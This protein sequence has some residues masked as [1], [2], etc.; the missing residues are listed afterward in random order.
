M[1]ATFPFTVTAAPKVLEESS[2]AL[3]PRVT[4][5]TPVRNSAKYIEQ[6]IY[7]VISQNYPNLEYIIVDGAS[8]DG[9]IDIIRRYEKH[10]AWWTSEPDRSVYDAINKGFSRSSGEV[11]GWINASDVLHVGS[12]FVVGS[13][14]RTF[15]KVEWL[16]GRPTGLN[17]EGTVVHVGPVP[18]WS[19]RRFLMGANKYI[20]Q[21]STFWRRSLWEKAG[22]HVDGSK[23][24]VGDFDLWVRFF[25]HARLYSVDSLIGA[26]R[27]HEDAIS[28]RNRDQYDRG[29][30]D[31]IQAE[32]ES[33]SGGNA[34]RL[35]H[36]IDKVIWRIPKVRGVWS[37]LG[38]LALRGLYRIPG[39]DFTPV[40]HNRSDKWVMK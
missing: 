20:Q 13:V 18:H 12:L 32:L 14:F 34:L 26:Y 23:K 7:S 19:R 40:I 35:L 33:V 3:W 24:D 17:Q 30:D 8:T 6:T 28:L 15:P 1:A 36:R 11:L 38:R 16:T 4:V 29:C 10:L 39:P 22:G 37:R 31:I 21:E 9:T 27:S 25:R 2:A 5:V